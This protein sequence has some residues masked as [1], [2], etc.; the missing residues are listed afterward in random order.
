MEKQQRSDYLDVLKGITILLVVIGHCIQYGSGNEFSMDCW[1]QSTVFKIIYSFHMPLFSIISGYL[2]KFSFDRHSLK[3][4]CLSKIKSCVVPQITV[5][6][7]LIL[8]KCVQERHIPRI[9]VMIV[10]YL[11]TY[12]FLSGILI[13]TI[14]VL[15]VR[16]Y[17]N[18]NLFAYLTIIVLSV[19][20]PDDLFM[21]M[22]KFILPF[23]VAG[24]LV[25][26]K[27]IKL[28][29]K[30][31][32][33]LSL[34][35]F[36]AYMIMMQSWNFNS[37]I[38]SSKHCIWGKNLKLQLTV[39]FYRT[40]VGFLGSVWVM[41]AIYLIY[42]K[43]WVKTKNTLVYIGRNS[44]GIYVFSF[45]FNLWFLTKITYNFAGINYITAL[46]ESVIMTAV[47]LLLTYI[48]NKVKV[49]RILFLG[50]R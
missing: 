46:I 45:Y 30:Q 21:Y 27:D 38:Y 16:K 18:D 34:L 25:N 23:F 22:Y 39:D 33:L 29:K 44:I 8:I 9:V 31:V 2:L 24:Y 47:C 42:D 12:W 15:I 3:K 17:L 10:T 14:V 40:I 7:I 35:C 13:C 4:V 37:Y 11:E 50:G 6:T 41:G 32:L 19:F 5:G 49:L 28:S 48:C 20:V 1:E 43:I 36:T 26:K